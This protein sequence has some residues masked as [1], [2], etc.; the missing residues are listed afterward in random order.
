MLVRGTFRGWRRVSATL[1]YAYGIESFEDLTAERIENVNAH[2]IA[3]T[4]QVRLPSLT[5]LAA[6]WEHQWRP[7]DAR[8]DRVTMV[9]VQGF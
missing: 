8:L 9:V 7:D 5:S 1:G 4:V 3:A 2:T 6:T